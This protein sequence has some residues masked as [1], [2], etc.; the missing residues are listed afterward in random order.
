MTEK[1][2]LTKLI[3]ECCDCTAII[4][5]IKD[6]CDECHANYLIK[7]GVIVLPAKVG[8]IVYQILST[9]DG[10]SFYRQAT[11]GAVHLSETTRNHRYVKDVPYLVLKVDGRY[12]AHINIKE[13]GKTV[14]L[15]KEE[16]ERALAERKKR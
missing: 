14:F 2:K 16:A 4:D 11:V 12:C 1:E 10:H 9:K 13:I 6:D 8:D 15:T 3:S 5:C 7:N